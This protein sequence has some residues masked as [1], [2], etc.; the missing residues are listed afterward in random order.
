[1][2]FR[3]SLAALAAALAACAPDPPAYP[4][5]IQRPSLAQP[6]LGDVGPFVSMADPLSQ[7]HIVRDVSHAIEADAW[8]W[9]GRNPELRFYLESV[10][11]LRLQCEFAIADQ[12]FGDTGPVTVTYFVNG[13]RLDVRRYENAGGHEYVHPVPA[14]MLRAG[15]M[16]TVRMQIEPAWI[17]P[18]DGSVLGII[19]TRAGFTD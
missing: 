6:R 7:A 3:G 14:A 18:A 5:P 16:N 12:T 13:Q 10:E 1:M 9:T 4:P 8:R 17:S 15:A 2:R 19:L 11:H